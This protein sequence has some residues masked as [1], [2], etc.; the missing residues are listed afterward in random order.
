MPEEEAGTG[1]ERV[2][3]TTPSRRKESPRRVMLRRVK[4]GKVNNKVVVF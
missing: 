4:E 3:P 1:V 2:R